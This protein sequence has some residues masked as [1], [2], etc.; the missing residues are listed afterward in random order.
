LADNIEWSE[1]GWLKEPICNLLSKVL[2]RF[3]RIFRLFDCWDARDKVHL[4][5]FPDLSTLVQLPE[6]VE[7][8]EDGDVD[9]GGQKARSIK[10]PKHVEPVDKDE[11][12]RPTGSPICDIGLESVVIGVFRGIVSLSD[13]ASAEE[14][15]SQVH[16]EPTRE[17][18]SRRETDEPME[19][20]LSSRGNI[21]ER[22]H[23]KG[24][25]NQNRNNRETLLG[26]ISQDFRCLPAERKSIENSGRTEQE[27]IS[28]RER[29]G[30][31]CSIDDVG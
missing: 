20:S 1:F 7:A 31:Y 11:E 13:E 23:A 19:D 25:A 2:W 30:E 6:K 14:D 8:H 12:Q 16:G 18:S 9:I 21:H 5:R 27:T 22:E 17:S 28:G 4:E 15:V 10:V 24:T 26:A 29:T 3:F